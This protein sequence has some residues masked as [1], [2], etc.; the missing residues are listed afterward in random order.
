M[1]QRGQADLARCILY[2]GR[3]E[4]RARRSDP[5]GYCSIFV[6]EYGHLVLQTTAHSPDFADVM[7]AEYAWTPA[8][9]ETAERSV[10]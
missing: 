9:C 1:P 4:H 10:R 7:H 8:V 3:R 2:I 6:H 5:W